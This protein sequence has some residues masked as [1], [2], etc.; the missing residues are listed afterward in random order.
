MSVFGPS[1]TGPVDQVSVTRLRHRKVY[2][3]FQALLGQSER[4]A[5]LIEERFPNLLSDL[6]L[7]TDDCM[8]QSQGFF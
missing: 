7:L 2:G 5:R 1:Q 3:T 8:V 6:E 4:V